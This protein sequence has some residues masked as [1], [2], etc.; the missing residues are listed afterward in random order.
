MNVDKKLREQ[1]YRE[2]GVWAPVGDEPGDGVAVHIKDPRNDKYQKKLQRVEKAYRTR[3]RIKLR[4]ELTDSQNVD[5]IFEAMYEELVDDFRGILKGG[6][7]MAFTQENWL[8]LM[9]NVWDFRDRVVALVGDEDIFDE[10]NLQV[11]EKNS[12]SPSDGS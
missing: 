6:E 4:K 1:K 9:E 5:V 10:D 7:E 2:E 8:W 11:V 12:P 3:N